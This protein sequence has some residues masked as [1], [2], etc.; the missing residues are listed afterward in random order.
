MFQPLLVSWT[1]SR[2]FI[3]P[4][5]VSRGASVQLTGHATNVGK[6]ILNSCLQER[7]YTTNSVYLSTGD[8]L[9]PLEIIP[10]LKNPPETPYLDILVLGTPLSP[11]HEVDSF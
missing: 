11:S 4:L 6:I 5:G 9:E 3:A 2:S 8:I 10:R 7:L 1:S